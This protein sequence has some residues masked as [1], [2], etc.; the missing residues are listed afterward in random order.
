M[1]MFVKTLKGKT[2]TLEVEIDE[3]IVMVKSKIQDK[4]RIPPNQQRLIF[5]GKQ[6]EDGRTLQDY[7]ILKESTLHLVLRLL[8]C[9]CGCGQNDYVEGQ[10]TE[11]SDEVLDAEHGAE[12]DADSDIEEKTDSDA[13]SDP[14]AERNTIADADDRDTQTEESD[15]DILCN[16]LS[17][18]AL[19]RLIQHNPILLEPLPHLIAAYSPRLRQMMD[20]N[21]E[22]VQQLLAGDAA[23]YA[24][25]I[26]MDDDDDE[27][28]V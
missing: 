1:Q 14:D 4:E 22:A 27:Q 7:N 6:I 24:D 3:P 5:A 8:G 18:Q 26:D 25:D 20:K 10:L 11:E 23:G 21:P 9:G 2:I 16:D 19:R 13:K 15:L 12:T 28:D 17:F